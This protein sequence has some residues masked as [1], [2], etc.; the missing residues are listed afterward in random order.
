MPLQMAFYGDPILRKKAAPVEEITD[1]I[2]QLVEEMKEMMHG[3]PATGRGFSV[4]LAG[5][6]VH[7]QLAIFLTA[8]PAQH[9]D[10]SWTLENFR[11]YINPKILEYSEEMEEDD[12]GCLSIPDLY[13]PVVRPTRVVL[14]ATDLEGNRFTEEYTDYNARRI[15]HENDH[16]NGVLFVDRIRGKARKQLEPILQK[17]KKKYYLGK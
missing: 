5:P 7:K 11:I 8:D 17:L 15:M 3:G 2:R 6:Q 12:E 9:E 4:G 13:A 10:E 1:E 14:E 16:L